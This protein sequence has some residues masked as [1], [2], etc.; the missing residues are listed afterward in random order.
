[1]A[2]TLIERFGFNDP[3]RK[4]PLHDQICLWVNND[5]GEVIYRAMGDLD[6]SEAA[7]RELSLINV[8]LDSSGHKPSAQISGAEY[9]CMWEVPIGR[10]TG[11]GFVAA[12][13]VD[14][15]LSRSIMIHTGVEEPIEEPDIFILPVHKIADTTLNVEIKSKI[16]SVG[17]L[18]RQIQFYRT[19]D[20]KT[21]WCVVS[22]DTRYAEIIRQQGIHFVECPRHVVSQNGQLDL[23]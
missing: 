2:K 13:F 11:S 6:E 20:K 9:T 5:P 1:M 16:S 12:G 14:L 19:F 17:D 8:M 4:T 10:K 7:K 22:P 23:F 18:L 21:P 3:D 15:R